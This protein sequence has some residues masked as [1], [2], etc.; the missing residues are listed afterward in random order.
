MDLERLHIEIRPRSHFQALD[1]GV[2]MARRWYGPLLLLGAVPLIVVGCVASLLLYEYPAWVALIIWWCKPAFERLPLRYLS[3]AIFEGAT[4][5]SAA[6]SSWRSTVLPGLFGALTWRRLSPR[7]SFDAPVWVLERLSGSVLAERRRVLGGRAAGAALWLTVVGIHVESFLALALM[8]TAWMFVP[9]GEAADLLS[10]LGQEAEWQGWISTVAGMLCIAAILPFYVA[11]GFSLYLN[12]RAELEAWDLEVTF[13]RLASR[14]VAAAA[15][16]AM[17]VALPDAA[18]AED[19]RQVESQAA[20]A[21]VL[22]DASF[23]SVQ[24]IRY[25]AFLADW[26]DAEDAQDADPLA[27]DALFT[28]VAQFGEV[29]L[30]IGVGALVVWILV[31]L[32]LM[33]WAVPAARRSG[34]GELPGELFG[35]RLSEDTL[36][37]DVVGA[38]RRYWQDGDAR[39]ALSLLLRAAL[40][41]MVDAHGC[42]FRKGDT[43]GDCAAEVSRSAPQDVAARFVRLIDQ[44][45][46]V[47]YAHRPVTDAAFDALCEDWSVP[48]PVVGR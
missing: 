36:P 24:T 8:T 30:W 20:I 40:V 31:R 18:W 26:L 39:S 17:V 9:G 46:L 7:R 37:D 16:C 14:L 41:E 5:P 38:A 1:L 15:L 13:R 12:R 35:M 43:E 42:S 33:D 2:L 6:L 45:R 47:A 10:L 34:R 32:N 4:A 29:L 23:T 44:W 21:E 22:E 48:Q 11:C 25:P 3:Q 27:W 19:A 28:V